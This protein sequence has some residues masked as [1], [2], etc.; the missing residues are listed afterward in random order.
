MVEKKVSCSGH[1]GNVQDKDGTCKRLDRE[2]SS[3][4]DLIDKLSFCNNQCDCSSYSIAPAFRYP[5]LPIVFW[6]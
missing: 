1:H 6:P 3:K 2:L 4:V 5:L